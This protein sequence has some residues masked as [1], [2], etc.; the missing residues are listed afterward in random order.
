MENHITNRS[1]NSELIQTSR[2]FLGSNNP[3][4]WVAGVGMGAMIV[5]G[6]AI[7]AIV[8]LSNAD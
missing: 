8:K 2:E 7:K 3:A 5:A 6:T 1:F 4:L